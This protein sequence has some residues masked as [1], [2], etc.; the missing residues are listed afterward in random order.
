MNSNK[1]AVRVNWKLV[2]KLSA[3]EGRKVEGAGG[4]AWGRGGVYLVVCIG[5]SS[6]SSVQIN[7]LYLYRKC[8]I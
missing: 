6:H 1:K 4:G 5:E 8:G 2:E 7:I 3:K